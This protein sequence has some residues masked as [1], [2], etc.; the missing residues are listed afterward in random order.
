MNESV[1]GK[2]FVL[3]AVIVLT[4]QYF[5]S[6]KLPDYSTICLFLDKQLAKKISNEP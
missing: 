1:L 6:E 4:S 2:L 3:S 5:P